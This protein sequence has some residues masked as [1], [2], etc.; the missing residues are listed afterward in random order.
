MGIMNKSA[1]MGGA[2]L[3][4]MLGQAMAAAP[5]PAFPVKPIRL[6]VG[7]PA[8]GSTDVLSR[9]VGLRLSEVLGQQIVIDNRSGATGS[10]AAE[11]VAK[12]A[13]DG[14]TLMMATV[15]SHGINPAL[16]KSV[17]YDAARDF[18]PVTLVATYPL[19]LAFNANAG[20][21][22]VK[23]LIAAAKSK[24][25]Q[26]RVSSSGNGS[27]GHLAAEVFKGMAGVDLQHIPYKGGAPSTTAV[28]SGEAQLTFA[29]LPGMMPHVKSGRVVAVAV[30]TAKRSPAVPE[31]PTV[32]E[33][34]LAGYNVSSWAGVVG[35]AGLHKPA[36][37]RLHAAVLQVLNNPELR[38][39]LAR[40]G[41]EPVGN[42]P[43]EFAAF[44]KGELAMWSKAV[45]QAGI[46]P[47]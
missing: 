7:F 36:L 12:S 32:A 1:L 23:D 21:R 24:P 34:G 46:Q 31:V 44:I 18:Q 28:L 11:I 25:G 4:L 5:A 30:T 16:L 10:L 45:K 29:T 43:A 37:D 39:Q 42:S 22:S 9:Q 13:A 19:L 40:E 2:V 14:Y 26:L 38:Q 20:V 27:P 8:G 41:A 3:S 33:A 17:R 47:D 35:P 6:V 15:A